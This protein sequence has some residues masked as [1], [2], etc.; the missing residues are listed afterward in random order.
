[1]WQCVVYVCN[2]C[3]WLVKVRWEKGV[4]GDVD[5]LWGCVDMWEG[6]MGY[7]EMSEEGV[8]AVREKGICV[9]E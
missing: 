9:D 5:K 8:G 4:M 6:A 3:G 2:L 7:I 1:M